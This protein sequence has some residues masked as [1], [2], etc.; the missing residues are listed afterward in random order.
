[1][2]ISLKLKDK[3]TGSILAASYL[4]YSSV[5]WLYPFIWLAVLSLT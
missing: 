2:K 1:M 3:H 4:G 5:F